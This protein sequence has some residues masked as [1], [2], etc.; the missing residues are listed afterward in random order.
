MAGRSGRVVDVNR[1]GSRPGDGVDAVRR[2]ATLVADPVVGT[3]PGPVVRLDL[4]ATRS[5][6]PEHEAGDAWR[7]VGSTDEVVENSAA[8][9]RRGVGG[10]AEDVPVAGRTGL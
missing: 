5:G 7:V 6:E 4:L 9:T 10:A 2:E 8:C 1:A 3:E